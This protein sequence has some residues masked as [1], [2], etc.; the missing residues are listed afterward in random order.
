ADPT[1]F[2]GALRSAVTIDSAVVTLGK[3]GGGFTVTDSWG[4]G[5]KFT[6][7]RRGTI[8]GNI[9]RRN[10]TGF[11]VLIIEEST[12][13][14]PEP[15]LQITLQDNSAFDNTAWGFVAS[16]DERHTIPE[17][18][19]F[20]GNTASGNGAGFGQFGVGYEA[21]MLANISSRNGIGIYVA[22]F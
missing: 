21:K 7:A 11:G 3:D 12:P 10:A 1:S 20:V 15:T 16:K 19:I 2:V 13:P 22:G 14:E 6:Q 5:V 17:R 8:V 4:Y 18:I 9:A